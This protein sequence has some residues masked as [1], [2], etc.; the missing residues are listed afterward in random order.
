MFFLFLANVVFPTELLAYGLN[1]EV[2]EQV[3]GEVQTCQAVMSWS[4]RGIPDHGF[5]QDLHSFMK[6]WPKSRTAAK[7]TIGKFYLAIDRNLRIRHS[8]RPDNAYQF[9]DRIVSSSQPRTTVIQYGVEEIEAIKKEV[10]KYVEDRQKL[11][12]EFEKIKRE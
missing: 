1:E 2:L 6:I 4:L 7:T 3:F 12:D 8:M 9:I 10:K 5:Y 11:L